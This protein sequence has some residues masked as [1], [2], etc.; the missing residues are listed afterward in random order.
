MH[1]P[2]SCTLYEN[3]R[4][5]FMQDQKRIIGANTGNYDNLGLALFTTENKASIR[6]TAKFI[7]GCF[8]LRNN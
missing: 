1:L 5:K 2:F 3:R 7:A 4:I 6:A 8:T